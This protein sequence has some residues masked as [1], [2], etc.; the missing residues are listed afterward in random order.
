MSFNAI[1]VIKIILNNFNQVF[2]LRLIKP[3][4]NSNKSNQPFKQTKNQKKGDS[5]S[6]KESRCNLQ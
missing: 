4:Q 5:K 6:D 1:C 3:S 2:E